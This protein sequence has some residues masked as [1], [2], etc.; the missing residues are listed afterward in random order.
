MLTVRPWQAKSDHPLLAMWW[1]LHSWP[2]VPL[3][4]LPPTG[5]IVC[6]EAGTAICAGFL[7]KTDSCI[8]WLEWVVANPLYDKVLRGEALDQLIAKLLDEA[9]LCGMRQVFTTTTHPSLIS[10]YEKHGFLITDRN[11]TNLIRSF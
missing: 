9:V 4:A 1:T 8:G 2:V 6:D 5:Y 7:Y 10:R 3:A 11:N